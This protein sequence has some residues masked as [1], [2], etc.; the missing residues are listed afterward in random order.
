MF[1]SPLNKHCR[2]FHKLTKLAIMAILASEALQRE[3]KI[4]WQNVTPSGNRTQA[5]SETLGSFYSHALLI[6]LKSSKSKHQVVHEQKFK[7]LLSRICQVIVERIVLDL[8]SEALQLRMQ[9]A[10]SA[11]PCVG[12]LRIS[13]VLFN[14]LDCNFRL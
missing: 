4:Q 9:N 10:V 5:A 14:F 13:L 7:D 11:Q 3:K 6:F 12:K 1:H 8:E 2:V